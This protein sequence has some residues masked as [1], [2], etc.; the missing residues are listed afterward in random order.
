MKTKPSSEFCVYR[1]G[2]YKKGKIHPNCKECQK[3]Y[4]RDHRR[5]KVEN[6]AGS[7]RP[8]TCPI[9]GGK[10]K[11]CYD[12]D[13][14]TGMFRG[15]LC[16]PCNTILGLAKDDPEVLRGLADYLEGAESSSHEEIMSLRQLSKTFGS[17]I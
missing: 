6:K 3:L 11:I 7:L 16:G 1:T 8:D 10:D 9:C 12:H 2:K 13:H 17:Y 5:T 14:T 15:W 4:A